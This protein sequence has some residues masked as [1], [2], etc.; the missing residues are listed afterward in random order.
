MQRPNRRWQSSSATRPGMG[1][2][3]FPPVGVGGLSVA[4]AEWLSGE[5]ARWVE[6]FDRS[7]LLI[8]SHRAL[9]V[10]APFAERPFQQRSQVGPRNLQTLGPMG[11]LGCAQG[12]RLFAG[13]GASR[14]CQYDERKRR[15]SQQTQYKGRHGP[16]HWARAGLVTNST[17]IGAFGSVPAA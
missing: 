12:A 11:E 2:K 17:N 8:G 5:A 14:S 4:A 7:A 16:H 15:R 9:A 13:H 6:R 10:C 3:A 1:Q